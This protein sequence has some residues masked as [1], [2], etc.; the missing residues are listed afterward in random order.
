MG[1]TNTKVI[2]TKRIFKVIKAE[3]RAE[4]PKR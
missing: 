3:L 1:I 4:G 2:S